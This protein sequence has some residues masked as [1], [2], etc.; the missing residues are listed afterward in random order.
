MTAA[1][2]PR[3]ADRA[4][5]PGREAPR[6][7]DP[8]DAWLAHLETMLAALHG[9]LQQTQ[10]CLLSGG[11]DTLPAADAAL[12]ALI[13]T[14]EDFY[15]QAPAA[16]RDGV[17]AAV[18]FAHPPALAARWTAARQ[19]ACAVRDL[20]A[21]NR[22]IL[23]ERLAHHEAALCALGATTPAPRLYSAAGQTRSV[24]PGRSLGRA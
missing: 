7:E 10:A 8:A 11:H 1:N 15:A 21:H 22:R 4:P 2:P 17:P 13:H 18:L 24:R 5:R 6:A 19:L 14:L 16:A 9:T 23:Q 20:N 3:T 12:Q